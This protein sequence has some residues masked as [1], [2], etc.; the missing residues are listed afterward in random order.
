ML[1]A[2][3]GL[4]GLTAGCVLPKAVVLEK[5]AVPGGL[6]LSPSDRGFTID[7]VPHVFFTANQDAIKF[8]ER[9][10]GAGKFVLSDSDVRVY[11]HSALTRFPFQSNLRGLPPGVIVEC[12]CEL[13]DARARGAGKVGN[14]LDF[15]RATF[16]D[17]IVKHFLDPY[18]RKL[19]GVSSLAD[20]TTDWVSGKVAALEPREVVEGAFLDRRFTRLPNAQ[21]RYPISGGIQAF[22]EGVARNAPGLRLGQEIVGIDPDYR[23]AF[24][25]S[26]NE[27]QYRSMIYTLPLPALP[28]LCPELPPEVATAVS[29]LVYRDVFGVHF[30]VARKDVA[31]WHWMYFPEKE[32]PFYRVSFPSAMSKE[33]APE[34]MSCLIAEVAV[35]PGQEIDVPSLI[36]RCRDSLVAARVLRSDDTIL[37]A[38]AY[39][40]SPAYVVYN[41]D[42]A[43]ALEVIERYLRSVG[44]VT[45]GRFGKWRFF[46][47]DHTLLSGL[48]AAAAARGLAAAR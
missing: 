44:I 23:L 30:G 37:L 18:N 10:V 39:R 22:A 48:E 31:T 33:N 34:G 7:L 40:L 24:T 16:G 25:A 42:R 3:G 29:R 12:L 19:W 8:F 11:S 41:H 4:A 17:G 32:Y 1:V 14:F 28:A 2:G 20:L 47:M 38:K 6:L 5:A 13:A 45:A 46:N 43:G 36:D 9:S 15:A 35:D 27:Y 26:G 21:F